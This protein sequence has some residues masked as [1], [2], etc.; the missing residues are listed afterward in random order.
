[1]GLSEGHA[2]KQSVQEGQRQ[3]R[4]GARKDAALLHEQEGHSDSMS[5]KDV[6]VLTQALREHST[7]V[8]ECTRTLQEALQAL[9]H[10]SRP[11]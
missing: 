6:V 11:L 7:A 1:M 2:A 4:R 8:A 9:L 3:G 10:T 5:H